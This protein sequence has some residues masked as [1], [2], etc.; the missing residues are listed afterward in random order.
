MHLLAGLVFLLQHAAPWAGSSQEAAG[1]QAGRQLVTKLA[2]TAGCP[3][4][5]AGLLCLQA[6][7][8]SGGPAGTAAAGGAAPAAGK[9]GRDGQG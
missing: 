3:S 7:Q 1:R 5:A 4:E 9:P 2:S 8:V 6:H